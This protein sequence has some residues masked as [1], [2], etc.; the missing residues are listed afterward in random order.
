MCAPVTETH[1]RAQ[2][3]TVWI[4]ELRITTVRR[5][6]RRLNRQIN[7]EAAALEVRGR[8]G[9]EVYREARCTDAVKVR[10][11]NG[12]KKLSVCISCGA[13]HGQRRN[14]QGP[15]RCRRVRD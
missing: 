7:G 12:G 4:E 9:G 1:K 15:V 2:H 3:S 5:Q 14:P 10:R 6:R 13:P 11:H 8:A